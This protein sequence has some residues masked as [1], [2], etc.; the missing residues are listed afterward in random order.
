MSKEIRVVV[1]NTENRPK[2]SYIDNTLEAFQDLVGGSIEAI[3]PFNDDIA[4]ICNEE[5]KL[6]GLPPNRCLIGFNGK[7]VDIIVGPFFLVGLGMDD[8]ESIPDELVTKYLEM[9]GPFVVDLYG[10]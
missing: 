4:L 6:L 2:V 8:Y 10:E 7:I 5:G 1:V 3:Y 9:F